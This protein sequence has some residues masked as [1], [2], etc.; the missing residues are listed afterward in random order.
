MILF[1]D[2]AGLL[3][4][5]CNAEVLIGGHGH[6]GIK[7]RRYGLREQAWPALGRASNVA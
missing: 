4:T 1:A 5:G 2:I 6:E 3:G 7:L